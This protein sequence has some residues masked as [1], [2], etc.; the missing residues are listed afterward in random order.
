LPTGRPA[1]L[2]TQDGDLVPEDEQF[3]GL[4]RVGPREPRQPSEH[5]D[6]GQVEHPSPHEQMIADINESPAH[7]V[8][9]EFWH[10]TRLELPH[11][12]GFR[13]SP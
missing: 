9:D 10:G 5:L 4:R 2:P 3:G 8:C 1:D 7:R 6:H 13:L 12:F 11:A